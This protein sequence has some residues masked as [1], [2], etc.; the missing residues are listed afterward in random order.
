[1]IKLFD[2]W[3]IELV[4]TFGSS[5]VMKYI[6]VSIKMGL[7]NCAPQ[8]LREVCHHI[9]KKEYLLQISYT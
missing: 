2:L 7:S 6:L 1:M 3:G 8:Q 5:L 4:G 9:P